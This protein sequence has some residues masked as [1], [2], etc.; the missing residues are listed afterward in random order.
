MNQIDLIE[1]GQLRKDPSL[2]NVGDA[3]KVYMKI[4]EGDK[5]RVQVFEGTVI[6]KKKGGDR[7]SFTVRKVSYTVG[8]ERIFP[9]HSPLIERIEV[10]QE[11]KVR[12]SR[13]YYLR[14]L[15]GKKARVKRRGITITSAAEVKEPALPEANVEQEESTSSEAKLPQVEEPDT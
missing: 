11:G 10:V 5:E 8:V 3:V 14:R 6:R 1:K 12:R 15:R 2:F 9:L 13:L 4:K 7:A